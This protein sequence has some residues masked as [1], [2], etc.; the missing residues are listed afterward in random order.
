MNNNLAKYFFLFPF[1]NRS[2][3]SPILVLSEKLKV[4]EKIAIN[5]EGEGDYLKA[6]ESKHSEELGRKWHLEDQELGEFPILVSSLRTSPHLPMLAV[7]PLDR[8]SMVLMF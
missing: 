3:D 4:P 8:K 2:H 5:L 7:K 1:L 6:L